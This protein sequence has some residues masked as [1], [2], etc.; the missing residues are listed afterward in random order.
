[1][2]HWQRYLF[3]R[4]W[5][6]DKNVFDVWSGDSSGI[7]YAGAFARNAYAYAVDPAF[8]HFAA[9]RYPHVNFQTDSADFADAD[10]ILCF[11]AIHAVA[12][13]AELLTRL[14]QSQERI[15]V[16]TPNR[17]SK[18]A[19]FG[20]KWS[21]AEFERMLSEF[22]PGR[23]VQ[24]LSQESRWP[25]LI[26]EGMNDDARHLIAVI[27]ECALP[28]WPK[29]G[30]AMPTCN[31]SG[32]A[33]EAIFT[34]GKF[35]PGPMH[36]AVVA[37]GSSPEALSELRAVRSEI[38]YALSLIEEPKNTGYG[39]GANAGLEALWTEEWYDYFGVVND[40]V[41]PAVDCVCQMVAAIQELEDAG[42]R[43]GLIGPVSNNVNGAQQIDIGRYESYG[44][45]LALSEIY[46]RKR[47]SAA[48]QVLQ[49][50]G[51]FFLMAPDCLSDV[52]GFDARY[53]L[54][55]FE[56]DDLNVRCRLAGYSVWIA[57]GAFLHHVG[58]ST[59]RDLN[60][61]YQANIAR[62]M[63]LFFEKWQTSDIPQTLSLTSAPEGVPVFIPLAS[64]GARSPFRITINGEPVDLVHQAT[65]TEF[66]AWIAT[67]LRDRSREDR[68]P[69][70]EAL[71]KI[72]PILQRAA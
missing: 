64:Q 55:N 1:M 31:Q 13:S 43:P 7:G 21:P 66:A 14:S 4:S 34:L 58:S 59:F 63:S 36:F 37:N 60:L 45:M 68:V 38:P 61:D 51:L 3:F 70:L 35:Y 25:G 22:F 33:R 48:T 9:S 23:T 53:G 72:Y 16:S 5:Y 49:L 42:H 15:V 30:L 50:R 56:D 65:E 24:F 12:D 32:R 54:G 71:E 67:V 10:V 20:A 52:G 62:N 44:E 26:S 6:A 40:D 27:G 19:P 47:H 69:V 41:I 2:F 28:V 39:Q 8:E 29:I 11:E 46:H 18:S 57:D 17:L